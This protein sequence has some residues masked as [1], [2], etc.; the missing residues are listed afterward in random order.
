[1]ALKAAVDFEI[2]LCTHDA[3]V[4]GIMGMLRINLTR[5]RREEIEYER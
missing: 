2:D 4:T 1:M 3:D 5:V